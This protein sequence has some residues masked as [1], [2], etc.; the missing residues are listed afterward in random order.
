MRVLSLFFV[1]VLGC[2]SAYARPV[3]VGEMCYPSEQAARAAGVSREAIEKALREDHSEEGAP[4]VE[5]VPK[6]ASGDVRLAMGYMKPEAM[7]AFLRNQPSGADALENHA[8]IVVLLLILAGGLLANLTPC[9]LPLVP[10]N[11][12]LVGRGWRRG[13]AYGLGIAIAYGMLGV[14]A[15]FGGMA[16]GTIQSSP[17]FSL[18]VAI[19]FTMLGLAMS[20]VFFIDF[21][22]Y[23]RRVT[24]GGNKIR[25]L[26]GVFLLGVG[27]AVLAGACV[28]PILLA[29]LVLT[30]KW[31]AAGKTWAVVLP[32]ILGVGMGLPWPF[33]AA[34]LSVLPKPGAWMRWVN[35]IFAL[36]LFGMAIWYGR[37][38]WTGFADRSRSDR[39]PYS[40][41]STP[42]TSGGGHS[43]TD[44][45]KTFTATPE[46]WEKVFAEAKASDRPVFVDVWASWCKNCLAM[47]RTTFRA[48]EVVRALAP[49]T[50]VRLQAED[51]VAFQKLKDF[52][53]L[54]IKGFPAFV[55]FPHEP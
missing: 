17:W 20:E 41:A 47:E 9:V 36:V 53:N 51:P 5:V 34:G 7:T 39:S 46:T 4:V 54:G 10:V 38:A 13:A 11:L 44:R 33:A 24:G 1:A 25:G 23:R 49:F 22:K 18:L 35:R 15:A 16:F 3:C 27:A 12:V 55:I 26:G 21:T 37:L 52:A 40:E 50:V 28:E 30:A 42:P 29:T 43:V 45:G 32:F 14:A 19:V 6:K 2:L 8:L 48:P 31:C